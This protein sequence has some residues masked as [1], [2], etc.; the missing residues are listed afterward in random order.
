MTR[1]AT[2]TPILGLALL[3]LLG[4]APSSRP[5][6]DPGAWP[7]Q[8]ILKREEGVWNA[9]VQLV[10][11]PGTEPEVSNGVE[12]NL[13]ATGGRWLISDF[14]GRLKDQPFQGHGVLGYDA[15]RKRFVRAWVDT[16][17][18]NLWTASGTYDPATRT[19]TMWMET[20]DASGQTQRFRTTT[21]WKDN[22]TK[23]YT[24]YAPGPETTE[25]AGM[26]ITYRR[27]K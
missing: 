5:A 6:D 13:L 23:I 3:F 17:Q 21:I 12:T 22:D 1:H 15:A 27:R 7:E 11:E 20:P 18:T 4:A 14:K 8:E 26:I 24:M 10:P 9:T 16:T 19:L 2:Y 25:A